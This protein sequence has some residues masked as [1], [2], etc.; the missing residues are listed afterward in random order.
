MIFIPHLKI[1]SVLLL[2]FLIL[3]SIFVFLRIAFCVAFMV[4]AWNLERR[5]KQDKKRWGK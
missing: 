2:I 1:L 4:I 5:Y 3:S